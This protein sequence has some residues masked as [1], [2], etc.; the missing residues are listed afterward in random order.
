M[1]RSLLCAALCALLVASVAGAA[2]PSGEAG[3][4]YM[5]VFDTPRVDAAASTRMLE[6]HGA[7]VYRGLFDVGTAIVTLDSPAAMAELAKAPHVL[8]VHRDLRRLPDD[9]VARGT[10]GDRVVS[11]ASI[12][13]DSAGGRQAFSDFS[14]LTPLS[15]PLVPPERLTMTPFWPYQWDLMRI[16]APGAW[17]TGATGDPAVKVAIISSGIDYTHPEL[18]GRTDLDLSR[19]FVPEDAAQVEELFPGAHPIADLGIHGSYMASIVT[20]NAFGQSCGAPN[21]T[22]VGIKVQDFE[23]AMRVGDLVTG[24]VY[25]A[26]IGCDVALMADRYDLDWTNPDD[27]LD[28]IALRR[29]IQYEK[30]KGTLPVG[31]SWFTTRGELGID[32]DLDR[33]AL[34]MPAEG[35]M[36]VV[37]SSGTDDRWSGIA[38]FG[39]SLIDVAAPGGQV[40]Y[41]TVQPPLDPFVFSVGVCSSFT[42][43]T[44]IRNFPEECNKQSGPQ[45]IFSFGSR[46]AAAHAAAVAALIASRYHG[47]LNGY[48]VRQKLLATADDVGDPGVDPYFGH[49]RVNARRAVTE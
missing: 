29:A 44:R 4:H 21:V 17:A 8:G 42:Q 13:G 18:E 32:A 16:D 31:A 34:Q 1:K 11:L 7:T 12:I 47:H 25:A 30:L 5:V 43:F 38:D 45:Y 24:L 20:C 39:Y 19:N 9:A 23:E 35:G 37:A 49:G 28:I 48:F 26:D 33:N 2:V 40:D 3:D 27:R 41:D 15:A 36:L 46:P 6:E 14:R 22:L 10:N